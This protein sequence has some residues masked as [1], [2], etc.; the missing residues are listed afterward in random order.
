MLGAVDPLLIGCLL[1]LLRGQPA[2]EQWH[3][4]WVNAWSTLAS[5]LIGFVLVPWG[6][7]KWTTPAG[8]WIAAALGAT[9]TAVSIGMVVL[10]V[11]EHADSAAG[12]ILNSGVFRHLGII[13]Y[14]IYLWQQ[15]F[16]L[17]VPGML[18][19]GFAGML[20][21]AELSYWV[22]ERPL[23]RVRARLR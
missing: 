2:W 5:I 9:V 23:M 8:T 18:P 12:T 14:G 20:A 19:L 7:A 6:S 17:P 22:L 10:Y 21:M 1:A 4:R 11:V 3:R 16:T 13:S 15:L